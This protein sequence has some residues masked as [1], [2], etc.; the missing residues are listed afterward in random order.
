MKELTTPIKRSKQ[1]APLSREHHESL[2]FA[3]KIRQGIKYGTS[4]ESLV[5]YCNWFWENHL[6]DHFKKEEEAFSQILS[7]DHP[8]MK[9]MIDD[10]EAIEIK[11]KQLSEF[12]GNEG[13][14]RLAQIIIYHVRF[15]ERELFN[16][17]EQ[18]AGN[19]KLNS[20]SRSLVTEKSKDPKWNHWFWIKPKQSTT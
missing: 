4:N 3:W 5:E 9:K 11:L 18:I 14:E 13:F 2:L 8:M 16:Y 7:V 6:K 15:E 12:P 20:I 10:H 19:E 1:L 17:I